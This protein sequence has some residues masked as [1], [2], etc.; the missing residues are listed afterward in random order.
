M[1]TFN[2]GFKHTLLFT[3]LCS[4]MNFPLCLAHPSPP[5]PKEP[6]S[7]S[8]SPDSLLS[9]CPQAVV[10]APCWAPIGKYS[11]PIIVLTFLSTTPGPRVI[12]G[13]IPGAQWMFVDWMYEWTDN[14]MIK[15]VKA[16]GSYFMFPCLGPSSPLHFS[17]I[18]SSSKTH[19]K[20]VI[21][22]FSRRMFNSYCIVWFKLQA[23]EKS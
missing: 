6:V 5:L 13:H 14:S 17:V 7:K 12:Q 11:G 4:Y 9:S 10:V 16:R 21:L 18:T 19:W 2:Q 23:L 3:P 8:S 22:V 15:M 20:E 1:H